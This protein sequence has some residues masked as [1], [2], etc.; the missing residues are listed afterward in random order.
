[1][2]RY[3]LLSGANGGI[4]SNILRSLLNEGYKVISLDISNSNIK[5]LSTAFIKCDVTNQKELESAH[6]E[7]L[8]ITP[9]LY[10]IINTIGIF[11]MQSIIEGSAEDFKKFSNF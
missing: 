7:I 8:K 5:D 3:I 2:D 9:S 11:K 4:G 1:M 10:A 6:K